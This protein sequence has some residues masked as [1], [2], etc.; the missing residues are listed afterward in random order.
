M[1][2]IWS[3]M[4]TRKLRRLLIQ[5]FC[6]SII[7]IKFRIWN[8]FNSYPA[9]YIFCVFPNTLAR[10]L[11]FTDNPNNPPPYQF[12]LFASSIYGLSGVFDLILFFLTR[13]KVV[14]GHS[15]TPTK[16]A[17][18][19]PTH[20]RHDSGFSRKRSDYDYGL[21]STDIENSSGLGSTSELQSPSRTMHRV[22]PS[23]D[24]QGISPSSPTR[25]VHHRWASSEV[26]DIS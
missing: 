14:V 13:P 22:R 8:R 6:Q 16:D 10:W 19:L 4:T 18:V 17:A 5:C 11:Y 3:R 26:L 23:Y 9:V 7:F 15:I 24:L 1:L 21:H 25:S 12:T 20:F 2:W